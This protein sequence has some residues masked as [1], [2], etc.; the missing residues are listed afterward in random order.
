MPIMQGLPQPKRA[1]KALPPIDPQLVDACKESN[2][3]FGQGRGQPAPPAA[4]PATPPPTAAAP[5]A[6]LP[7]AAAASER[8]NIIFILTDDLAWNLVQYLP[9]VLQ[10]QKDGATFSNYFVTDSLCCPS[11]SSIFTGRFPH[12][13]GIFRNTGA[14]GGFRAFHS[15][16]EEQA[17]FATALQAAG[18][19]TAMLANISMATSPRRTLPSWAGACGRW[20]ATVTPS[21][22]TASIRTAMSCV[23]AISQPTT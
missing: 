23:T 12:D 7:A 3:R 16:H 9:H 5:S 8:P 1:S 15:R 14:D 20:P 6:P 2:P 11:R 19:R 18:Y 17:T 10:M 13:T 4:P 22:T 21:S